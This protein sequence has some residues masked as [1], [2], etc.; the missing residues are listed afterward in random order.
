[1]GLALWRF[2]TG[3]ARASRTM[4]RVGVEPVQLARSMSPL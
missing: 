3:R 1:M 4:S 2:A